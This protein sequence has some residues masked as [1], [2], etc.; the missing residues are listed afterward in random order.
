MMFDTT[1]RRAGF[2]LSGLLCLLLALAGTAMA[3]GDNDQLEVTDIRIVN[4]RGNT[5]AVTWRTNQATSD[6]MLKLGFSPG[7][8]TEIREDQL[9]PPSLIHYVETGLLDL[10]STYYYV[11]SSEGVEG[12]SS[13]VGYDSV[14][15]QQQSVPS[16]GALILGSVID[17]KSR[18]PLRNVIVR[19]YY[20][21]S[22]QGTE[23]VIV[24]STMWQADL[25]NA[26]GEFDFNMG[27][28]RRYNGGASPY[29]PGATWLFL[30]ILS[31]TSGK[32]ATDSVFL[33]F[34]V[35]D[36][37]QSQTIPPF[38]VTDERI[39]TR[40]GRITATGPVI[41]N[42]RSA[43]VVNITVLDE[44]NDPL[45]NVAVE[46]LVG[47]ERGVTI[48]QP[49]TTTDR[50]GQ[51]WGLVYSTVAE[52]KTISV[53]NVT[54]P[55]TLDHLPLD[56]VAIVQ[57]IPELTANIADDT[58][59]PFIYFTT[60]L[61]HT[62]NSSLPYQIIANAV[63]NYWMDLSLIYRI[64]DG[65]FA[66]TL[67][68]LNPD[69]AHIYT[70][71][72]PPQSFNSLVSYLVLAT[73]SAGHRA[74]RPDSIHLGDETVGPYMF[75]VLEDIGELVPKLGIT[76]T[77]NA[78][79]T[80]NSSLPVRI[81]TWIHSKVEI[82]AVVVKYR[83]VNAGTPWF[84]LPMDNFGAHHWA[85]IPPHGVGSK[86]DYFIQVTPMEGEVE[87]DRRL[88]PNNSSSYTYEVV[89]SG[90]LGT[91]SY[92]DTTDQL[93]VPSVTSP[94]RASA[95]A[96]FDEDGFLDVVVANYGG[97]NKAYY[98]NNALGLQ[99]VTSIA[100]G[101]QENNNTTHVA[102]A[103]VNADDYL[104]IIFANDGGQNR[105][106]INNALGQF[107]DM[108]FEFSEGTEKTFMPEEEWGTN[109]IVTADFDGDGDMDLYA[110]NGKNSGELNR[111]L[112]NDGNG[113]FFDSS[114]V[115]LD[116]APT[117]QSVWA[118][119]ADVDNDEDPDVVV[120]NRTG[121][122]YWM[123]NTGRGVMSYRA[124]PT[125]SSSNA[126]SGD[127]ADVDGDNDLDLVIGQGDL[128]QNELFL[129][130]GKGIFTLDISGRLPAESEETYGVKFFDANTDG[131]MDLLYLNRGQNNSLL[132]NN[133]L[134][135]FV[136]PP[137][138]LMREWSSNSRHASVADFNNDN[139]VD[140]FI[141]EEHRKNTILF[142]RNYD[143]DAAD[144]PSPFNL[145]APSDR[146]TVNTTNVEF[147]WNASVAADSTEELKY[148]FILAVDSLLSSG[149]VV[150]STDNLTDT[151]FVQGPL[152][153]NTRYWWK[154]FA[155]GSGPSV[156]SI[157][158][159]SFVLMTTHQGN[160]PEFFVLINRNPVFSGHVTAYIIASEPLLTNP[161]VAF[162]N[163]TVAAVSVSGGTIFRAHY[164]TRSN[165]LLTVSGF[166]LSGVVG[167][168]SNLF[169]STLASSTLASR[170][171]TPDRRAWIELPAS[172]DMLR[173]LASTNEPVP[174]GKLKE[175]IGTLEGVS[176]R[177]LR[178]MVEVESYS[179]T[180]MEG[181]LGRGA[182]I[183]IDGDG[184]ENPEK[185]AVCRLE[186]QGWQA[187]PTVFDPDTGRFSASVSQDG[188]YAL[189]AFGSGSSQLPRAGK[190]NLGQNS[191]NPFNPSTFIS[192]FVPGDEPVDGFSLKVFNLRG[193][194]VSTLIQGI[195]RPGNHTVQWTG[196]ADNGRE[197][198]SSVYFYRMSAPGTSIT[199]KMVLLR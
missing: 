50:N 173:L 100:F 142:S 198:P 114:D 37:G 21:W 84:D 160:G 151:S 27:N 1:V 25:T 118:I 93:G 194:V 43:S 16:Q 125:G 34:P 75:Q 7:A 163:E 51:A 150:G 161:T 4:L 143:P 145:L 10:D 147:V 40:N 153:D 108:T 185:M 2:L 136:E 60:I 9:A 69:S 17:A 26:D 36:L 187:L 155:Q 127:M 30:E 68:M 104:D 24:D 106:L 41:S 76:L 165:F 140:L 48:R 45:P 157:Q 79:T 67:Q 132:I 3:Q 133:S 177:D 87:R 159:H 164:V 85:D 111:L 12:A 134:G 66:D 105:L 183:Y 52:I 83:N 123:R 196:R 158:T 129:N 197:L 65:S 58:V 126:R 112:F 20:R 191:P 167:E 162:N 38:E 115:K 57:F 22:R 144:Q 77:T 137:V 11:V 139:R 176:D 92:A 169:S 18:Q 116:N 172:S 31:Q 131:Y 171:V 19:S 141:A 44:D 42:G 178:S 154:V 182:K 62:E 47:H 33:T 94:S 56:S 59:A 88:A 180:A 170:A 130:D 135:F 90:T 175:A 124:F 188:T 190:F 81:N 121:D 99:D 166:N 193:Q 55:D 181:G 61:G 117:L 5:F 156:S 80:T 189:L 95:V 78:T 72:I 74:S 174:D 179:F 96:D 186:K 107:D 89:T 97:V 73:D 70:G 35:S 168:Y 23:G 152:T 128:T 8:L 86:I 138:G 13:P 64:N 103:D 98:Y 109:C 119:V 110:A 28:F 53:I 49:Q 195:V 46:L 54:S 15:T 91:I 113:V 101:G 71:A 29:Y 102:V 6:N 32:I 14:I 120:I 122:H 63:D 82:N 199:R 148:S 184:V 39:V 149:S 192:F 146:D